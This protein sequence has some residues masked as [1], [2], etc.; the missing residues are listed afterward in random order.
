VTRVPY[1]AKDL[2]VSID[3]AE[4]PKPARSRE[5]RI[6]DG[7]TLIH[8]ITEAARER[9]L[10]PNQLVTVL[11]DVLAAWSVSAHFPKDQVLQML[12]RQYDAELGEYLNGRPV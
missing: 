11:C 9:G 5:Q 8:A 6:D 3:G 7:R 1:N 10:E 2:R 4:V 12:G